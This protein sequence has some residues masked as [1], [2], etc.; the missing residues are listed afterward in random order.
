M[1]KVIYSIVG[2]RSRCYRYFLD[3]PE[4]LKYNMFKITQLK[5]M[6][7]ELFLSALIPFGYKFCSISSRKM[8]AL[9]WLA[10]K[11]V[12]CSFTLIA[13]NLSSIRQAHAARKSAIKCCLFSMVSLVF[14]VPSQP[15]FALELKNRKL[16]FNSKGIGH[17]RTLNVST[18]GY[19]YAPLTQNAPKGTNT[20]NIYECSTTSKSPCPVLVYLHGGGLLRG[21]KGRVGLMPKLMNENDYC[22]VSV[23]YPVFGRPVKG[24]IEKQISEVSSATLWLEN[25]LNNISPNCTM[26]NASIMGH[27]AGAYL[28]ALLLTNP[29]FEL[30]SSLYKTFIF[31]DSSWYSGR[32]LVRHKESMLII[33]GENIKTSSGRKSLRN[34]WVPSVLVENS[35][36]ERARAT[37]ILVMYSSQRPKIQQQENSA[38]AMHLG[39]CK[40]ISASISAHGYN[41]DAMR[42]SIGRPG[43]STSGAIV[44]AMRQ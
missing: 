36:P 1:S 11:D 25:N 27:S 20:L 4:R 40:N 38:F 16:T 17:E 6:K 2:I 13:W 12:G 44:D 19:P 30:A 15:G 18:N 43:S 32:F 7:G 23:N 37:N 31:N 5:F 34:E 22:L 39:T 33:F 14:F 8:S 26:E 28:S 42:T 10:V 41:H 24:L 9:L 29:R 21:D 35:C 3:A